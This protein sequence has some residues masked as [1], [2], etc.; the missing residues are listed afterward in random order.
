MAVDEEN[1]ED[2]LA[3]RQDFQRPKP[4]A[5]LDGEFNMHVDSLKESH[6][7]TAMLSEVSRVEKSQQSRTMIVVPRS[8]RRGLLGILT[9][10]PEVEQPQN[11]TNGMKW[12]ITFV[13]ALAGATAP[14]GSAIFFRKS[15]L[16]PCSCE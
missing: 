1:I 7:P 12:L 6:E 15:L 8:K 16:I 2:V 4:T 5:T 9:L 11:Y 10:I 14:H 3:D 13:V